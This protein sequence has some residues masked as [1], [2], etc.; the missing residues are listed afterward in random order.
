MSQ[1]PYPYDPDI[2]ALIASRLYQHL[3]EL[4]RVQDQPRR[5]TGDLEAFLHVLAAPLAAVRQSI[6]ELYADLFID[7]CNDWVIP[8]LA[9]M[10]GTNLV[11]PDARSNRQ[12]VRGTVGWRR[13]KGTPAML[14]AM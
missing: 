14:E 1:W 12:D 5:N 8:Y 4:Y 11:F 13:S 10:I 2:R 7:S 9:D 6:E 3:P